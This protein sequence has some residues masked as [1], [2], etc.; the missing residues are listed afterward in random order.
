MKN[1]A[2]ALLISVALAAGGDIRDSSAQNTTAAPT[3]ADIDA[4]KALAEQQ[5]K[6]CHGLDGHGIAPGIP[7]LAG[8]RYH[9]LVTALNEYRQGQRIHAGVKIMAEN[10]NEAG[11]RH[12]GR[13]LCESPARCPRP[14]SARGN[15]LAL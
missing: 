12:G 1:L 6:G 7:N 11:E 8:Q 2:L 15:L 5:C 10:L 13:V 4:G 14:G 3:K 9:Y